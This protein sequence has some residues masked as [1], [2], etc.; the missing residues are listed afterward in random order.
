V[1]YVESKKLPFENAPDDDRG[2]ADIHLGLYHDVVVFDH[3]TKVSGADSAR[4]APVPGPSMEFCIIRSLGHR[5]EGH[6][7]CKGSTCSGAF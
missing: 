5:S 6:R 4:G 7:V 3:V 1:R 2:L